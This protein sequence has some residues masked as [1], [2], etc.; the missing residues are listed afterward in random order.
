MSEWFTRKMN[1]FGYA[2]DYF[3]NNVM[4][5]NGVVDDM[6]KMVR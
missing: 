1:S 5:G 6:A 3:Y 4:I 2:A